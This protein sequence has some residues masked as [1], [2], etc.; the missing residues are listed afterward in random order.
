MKPLSTADKEVL[1][2][3]VVAVLARVQDDPT[4]VSSNLNDLTEHETAPLS[5]LAVSFSD[6][7][8]CRLQ[9]YLKDEDDTKTEQFE[10]GL[11]TEE[12]MGGDSP[13]IEGNKMSYPRIV[14][15]VQVLKE[16]VASQTEHIVE[17][18]RQA[19]LHQVRK[20]SEP[21]SE[22]P[23]FE[24]PEGDDEYEYEEVDPYDDLP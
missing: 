2:Q 6:D 10:F 21:P 18:G 8:A 20:W 5:Y 16:A 22:P 9:V 1:D 12:Y 24:T 4:L 11:Y 23:S 14:E 15:V 13:V 3:V 17:R 19:V 7:D